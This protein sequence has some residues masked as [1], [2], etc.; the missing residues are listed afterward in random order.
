LK[1]VTSRR[2]VEILVGLLIALGL[3]FCHLTEL[4]KALGGLAGG[5]LPWWLLLVCILAY[6]TRIERLPL[7]SLGYRTPGWANIG[8]A[9]AFALGGIVG[10]GLITSFV[11]PALHLSVE[12]RITSLFQTPFWY[13]AILVTRAAF[14]EETAFRGYGFERLAELSG[15][16]LLAAAATFA[17]FT[18]AH[19]SG[20]GWGQ[21][22]VAA[23][24][25]LVLTALFL[26]RRNTWA[27]ILCHWLTDAAGFLL[28]PAVG[29]HH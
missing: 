6:T 20:G 29:G 21:V 12:R 27:N 15:S 1:A 4:G 7:A 26:W 23:W 2:R 18:L 3:P 13:R 14:V 9:F 24:G 25:G 22:I 10:I 5:E 28:L 19:Y 16:S 11:L 8:L 17:L